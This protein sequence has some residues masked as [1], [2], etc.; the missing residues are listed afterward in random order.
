MPPV[1]KSAKTRSNADGR[2]FR[3]GSLAGIEIKVDWSLLIIF[4]LVATSLGLGAFP[5]WHPD[6]GPALTWTVALSAAVLF[7]ASV[8]A[9]ELAHALVGRVGGVKVNRITLFIFGGMAHMKKEARSPQV[10]LGMGIAGPIASLVIGVVATTAGL[11]L[12]NMPQDVDTLS[13]SGLGQTMSPVATL[14]L[15]LGPINMLL[16]LFNMVPGFP[17]DGGRVLRALLWWTTGDRVRA[18]RWAAG[19]GTLVGFTLIATGVA[20]ALGVRVPLFGTGLVA[21]LWL[22]LIGWFLNAAARTSVQQLLLQ[23]SLQEVEV[24]DVMR[25]RLDSVAPGTRVEDLVEH[26]LMNSDQ[27]CFP[28]LDGETITGLVCLQDVRRTERQKWESKTVDQIMTR[29]ENL[30]TIS[31]TEHATEALSR[32]AEHEVDQIPVVEGGKLRGLIRRQD[33]MRW[34]SLRSGGWPT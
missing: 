2:G 23:E 8:L 33:I 30:V 29:V 1:E 5:Q 6:W 32:L 34:L 15:W 14:L 21:G 10:E 4:F 26:H 25:S 22:V 9:H 19:A 16:A 27:R 18:T 3:L 24:A 31:P 20:M 28:V 11:L 7:F 13:T 12:W 17:L